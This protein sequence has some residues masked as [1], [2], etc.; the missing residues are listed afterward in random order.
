MNPN[1]QTQLA[2][3]KRVIPELRL[4]GTVIKQGQSMLLGDELSLLYQ[5]GHPGYSDPVYDYK[6]IAGSYL[7]LPVIGQYISP[8]AHN[9]L[10][11]DVPP[12]ILA[13]I[14]CTCARASPE[15]MIFGT[16]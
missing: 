11:T 5:T 13:R 14:P 1:L 3:F 12:L 7:H 6:V 8:F 2:G 15:A 9:R 16:R 10:T 4:N